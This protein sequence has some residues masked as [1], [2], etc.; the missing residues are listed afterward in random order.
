MVFSGVMRL[1][2]RCAWKR[3]ARGVF[4]SA[5]PRRSRC[6]AAEFMPEAAGFQ[7]VSDRASLHE[8]SVSNSESFWGAVARQRLSWIRPFHSVQNCDLSRGEIKWFEGG[9]LNVSGETNF[10]FYVYWDQLMCL[11]KFT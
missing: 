4:A 3:A 8:Y 11:K 6:S 10:I 1:P 9:K 5:V 7:G 2:W